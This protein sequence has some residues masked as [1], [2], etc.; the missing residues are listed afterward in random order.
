MARA[1]R[2]S[3]R[4][5]AALLIVCALLALLA[6][7]L[8]TPTRDAVAAAFQRTVSRPLVALQQRAER[9]RAAF[10]EREA[11]TLRVDSL[12]VRAN[13]LQA[14][15]AENVRLR[16]LLAMSPRLGRAFIPAEALHGQSTGESHTVMLT[17]GSRAGIQPN[18]PVLGPDGVVGRV[19]SVSPT[20][21]QVILWSHP[22]FRVSAMSADGASF[23]IVTP[24]LKDGATCEGMDE[25][26]CAGPE[27]MLLEMRGVPF[28]DVLKPG[29]Q[30]VSS[31][32]GGVFPRG[33]AIGTVIGEIKNTT[34]QWTRTYLVRPATRPQDV[35]NVMVLRPGVQRDSLASVWSD[36]NGPEGL[37]STI[38]AAGDSVTRQAAAAL[39]DARRRADS[40]TAAQEAVV[41]AA[42]DSATAASVGDSLASATLANPAAAPAPAVSGR[43]PPV[44][45]PRRDSGRGRP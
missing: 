2:A 21:S 3:T 30:V 32:L 27:R 22:D 42:R 9:A 1:V 6:I 35:S 10:A 18:S 19:T 31:G 34:E 14:L 37:I 12:S 8:P 45:R 17:A 5:D 24:H 13:E 43:Q 15:D 7:V 28:R 29:V 44:I 38:I 36:P 26:S 4:V 40:V 33:M 41:Q 16:R 39:V 25:A 11:L 23:G 20:T